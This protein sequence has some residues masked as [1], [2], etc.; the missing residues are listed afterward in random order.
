MIFILLNKIKHII[1]E[2]FDI[3]EFIL[4]EK[5]ELVADLEFDSLDMYN[6]KGALEENFFIKVDD[7]NYVYRNLRTVGEIVTYIEGRIK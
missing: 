2:T 5:T 1:S 4:T 3:D 7:I 6:L